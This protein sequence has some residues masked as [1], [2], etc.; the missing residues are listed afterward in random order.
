M[1]DDL[2]ESFSELLNLQVCILSVNQLTLLPS[3]FGLLTSL[4]E[5]YLDNNRVCYSAFW[6]DQ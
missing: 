1:L 5:L 6:G 4:E 2:P 3:N